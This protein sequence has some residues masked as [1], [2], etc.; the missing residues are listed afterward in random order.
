MIVEP[1]LQK[2]K[3]MCTKEFCF[4]CIYLFSF[5]GLHLQ[6]VEVPRLR[7]EKELQLLA[8]AAGTANRRSE[9]HLWPPPPQLVAMLDL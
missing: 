8:Y 2:E 3:V 5:L 7:V 9:P 6:H 4:V 1:T